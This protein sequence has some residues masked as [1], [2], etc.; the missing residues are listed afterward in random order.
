M[1]VYSRTDKNLEWDREDDEALEKMMDDFLACPVCHKIHLY[2]SKWYCGTCQR[3]T[4]LKD[5][6]NALNTYKREK[7]VQ[8]SI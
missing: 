3:Q 5:V 6:A 4:T 2:S 7:G 8:R 1:V